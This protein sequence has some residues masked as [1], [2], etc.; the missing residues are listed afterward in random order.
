MLIIE[1]KANIINDSYLEIFIKQSSTVHRDQLIYS[2][3]NN[4]AT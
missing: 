1:I 2:L 3:L 4:N